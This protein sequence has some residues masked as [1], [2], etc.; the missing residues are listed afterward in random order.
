MISAYERNIISYF[1]LMIIKVISML[2]FS[3]YRKA[4][5]S[6]QIAISQYEIDGNDFVRDSCIQRF[7]YTYEL[8]WKMLKRYLTTNFANEADY[9]SISFQNLIREGYKRGLL[10]GELDDWLQ[11]R[12]ARN[13]TSHTYDEDKAGQV[14]QTAIKF[15]EEA[16][17]LLNNIA[18][19]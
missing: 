17:H 4:I 16:K 8:S 18:N 3:A 9:N 11:Y 7:K 6:L 2:D 13:L 5:N 19:K 12:F 15:L 10:L 14:L 1:I